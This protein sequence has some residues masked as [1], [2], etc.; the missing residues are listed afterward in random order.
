[1]ILSDLDL[2]LRRTWGVLVF[3]WLLFTA[4]LAAYAKA[5]VIAPFAKTGDTD[6]RCRMR[7]RFFLT[8]R[9][10]AAGFRRRAA[11]GAKNRS[12]GGFSRATAFFMDA[13]LLGSVVPCGGR[14]LFDVGSRNRRCWRRAPHYSAK[15]PDSKK[16]ETILSERS[17][18]SP[19]AIT[20]SQPS[21]SFEK[22]T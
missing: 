19:R 16:V 18:C 11:R 1:M 2:E 10:P 15:F 6:A 22:M 7:R 5:D 14:R 8:R 13:R 3:C 21:L 20:I 17:K 4:N 9:A 12:R